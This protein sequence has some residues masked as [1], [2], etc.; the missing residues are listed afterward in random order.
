VGNADEL[1]FRPQSFTE[2]AAGIPAMSALVPAIEDMA[3]HAREALGE[4]RL[5]WLRGLPMTQVHGPITLV[6]ASPG[7]AWHG[8]AAN[9]SSADLREA[10]E[11]IETTTVVYGHIHHPYVR[12]LPGLTVANS[13]SVSLSYDGDP[14][15]SYLLLDD[16]MPSIRRVE[17]DIEAEVAALVERAVPH[18]AWTAKMLR[19]ARPQLP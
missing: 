10:Y 9:A 12:R 5:E 1:L 14:R 3:R 4:A 17:Y 7:S 19:S 6:H 8:P 16:A 13:G 18:A 2:F 15:A 11:A